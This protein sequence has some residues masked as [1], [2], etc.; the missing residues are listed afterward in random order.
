MGNIKVSVIIPVFND[1]VNLKRCLA[2]LAA[3]DFRDLEVIVVDDCSVDSPVGIAKDFGCRTISLEKQSGP[4]VAR[5]KGASLAQ[6]EILLFMDADVICGPETISRLVSPLEEGWDACVGVYTPDPGCVNF[7]SIYKNIFIW[8]YHS[9]AEEKIDWFWTACGAIK[10]DIFFKLGG[11]KEFYSWKSV[12]DIDF[13]YRLTE[14]NYKIF[15]E[16]KATVRHFH[17]F[18]FRGILMN[19]LK[20]ARDWTYFNLTGNHSLRF[21]HPSAQLKYRGAGILGSLLFFLTAGLSIIDFRFFYTAIFIFSI[22]PFMEKGFFTALL[23]Y[24]RMRVFVPALFFKPVDD[25]IIIVGSL[26]GLLSY[27]LTASKKP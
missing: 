17:Y 22:L 2:A 26:S 24:G 15:I 7:F 23:R 18:S 11:F 12:E 5:N 16:K 27:L 20:K 9:R 13:G 3:S 25:L 21:K 4:A 6:G 1:S 14:N 19:D 8:H 10:K